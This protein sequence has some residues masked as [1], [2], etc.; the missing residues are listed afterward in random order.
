MKRK[1][2][3]ILAA[4]VCF[5]YEKGILHNRIKVHSIDETI[6]ELLRTEKSMVRFGDGE[7]VMIKGGDLMLQKA[8]EEIADGLKEILAYRDDDLIVTI[9]DIFDGLSD[10]HKDSR[11][12]WRDHLLFCR[13]TYETYCNPDRVYYT[14]FVSRC[15]Y[16]AKDRTPCGRW[17]AKIRKIWENRDV[18]I[19]EGTR[20]H[21]GVGNDLLD[22]AKSVERIICP[23]SDAYSALPAILAACE[24]YEKDR[25][26]LLSVG[27]AAK[28]LAA[29]LF[30]QG[31]RVLDIG[32][33]DIEYEW[34][35]RQ[36]SGK[37]KLEKHEI[38]GEEAN[39]QAALS[40]EAYG[41][42]LRQ[43]KVW[44]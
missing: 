36:S 38:M 24:A 30:R 15:Y 19:V 11:Q 42:Y 5:L 13:K 22:T 43:V 37:C 8:S 34:Y 27:V 28:F 18:V 9:P 16:F 4:V 1:I 21:N 17:F 31:Y 35:V 2:K 40:G 3:D 29:E 25:L 33:L 44:L 26:F 10:H 12:F 23:P 7:I 6:D 32:N 41:T 20:T 39:R 14:T